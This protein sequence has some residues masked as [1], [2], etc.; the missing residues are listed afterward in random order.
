MFSDTLP[1]KYFPKG[2]N[3]LMLGPSGPRRLR[4]AVEHMCQYRGGICFCVDLD[5]RW[6]VKLIKKG[7]MEHLK[8][9][10]EHIIDQ[11]MTILSAGHDIKCMFTTPKLLDALCGRL[12]KEGT[13]PQGAGHHRHLLR[14]HRDDLAVDPLRHRGIPR[15]RTSTS[16]RPTATR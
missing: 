16:P 6:V 4:L 12:E 1:D 10:Q 11:A 2:R 15:R 9:Y 5:P 3:W 13:T 14:R 7:W 8:A